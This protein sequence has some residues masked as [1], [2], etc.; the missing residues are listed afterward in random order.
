MTPKMTINLMRTLFVV[1]AACIGSSIGLSL[2]SAWVGLASGLIG[3]GLMIKSVTKMKTMDPG[4]T[5]ANVFTARIGF[6]SAYTDTVAEWR[7]FERGSAF[8]SGPRKLNL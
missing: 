6:P 4:F 8:L 1:F 7:F 2:G 3:A 5:T